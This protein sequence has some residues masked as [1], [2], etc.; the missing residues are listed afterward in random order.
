MNYLLDTNVCIALLNGDNER[1]R[2][3]FERAIDTGHV[4]HLSSI[5][6]FELWYGISKSI[7]AEKNRASLM[8]FLAPIQ[9]T[10]FDSED[11][12][13]AGAQ[14]AALEKIERPIGPYDLLIAGQALRRDWTLVSANIAEFSRIRGLSWED[15]AR[16]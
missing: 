15:W 11:A 14:R 7:R 16:G 4:V 5:V 13:I 9:I 12:R 2:I 1:V 8:E 10:E 3:K 6:L